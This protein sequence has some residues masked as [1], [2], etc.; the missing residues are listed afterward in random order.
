MSARRSPTVLALPLCLAAAL[1]LA[2]CGGD[3]EAASAPASP[4]ADLIEQA[5]GICEREDNQIA[6]DMVNRFGEDRMGPAPKAEER[7]FVTETV[8]P[9]IQAQVDGLSDLTVPAVDKERFGRFLAAMRTGLKQA[10]ADPL[11]LTIYG[12]RPRQDPVFAEAMRLADEFGFDDC[13]EGEP[14]IPG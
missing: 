10:E 7:A 9:G 3:Q 2:A 12:D 11:E 6:E 8:I 5:D 4:S 1:W 14:D 13:T